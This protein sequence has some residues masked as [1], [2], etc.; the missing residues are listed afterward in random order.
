MKKNKKTFVEIERYNPTIENGLS[1]EQ[2][3]KRIEEKNV[4]N[5]KTQTSKTVLGIFLSNIFT[6]FN[7]FLLFTTFFCFF[8]FLFIIQ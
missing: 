1:T 5:T 2:I 8:L 4:N 7:F 6:F 3:D